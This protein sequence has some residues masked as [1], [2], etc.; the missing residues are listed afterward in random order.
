MSG[1]EAAAAAM[2]EVQGAVVASSLVL[3]AVFVPVAFFP[4]TTGQ[5]YR[6]FAMTIA[7]SIFR[8]RWLL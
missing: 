1:A 4:G 5:L 2:H 7:A 3:L 6:Q 8:T